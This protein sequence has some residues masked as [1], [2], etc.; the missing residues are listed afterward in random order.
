MTGGAA[1]YLLLALA[2]VGTHRLEPGAAW[3]K[4]PQVT[5]LKPLCGDEVGLEDALLSF[6]TQATDFPVHYVFGATDSADP[7]L[8][9]CR[10]VAARFPQHRADFVI[11]ASVQGRNP[12]ISNLINMSRTTLGDIVV[13]SDSD[14]VI[15]PGTLQAAIDA[16]A[17]PGVG[18]ATTLYRARPAVA[19]DAVRSFGAW[20]VDYWDLPMQMLSARLGP[21]AVAYGPLTAVHRSVLEE[22]GGLGSLADQLCDD[23]ALGRQ[24]R[25]AGYD[26]VFTPAIAETLVNDTRLGQLFQHELRWARTARGLQPLGYAASVVAMPGPLPLLLLLHPGVLTALAAALPVALRWAIARRVARRFGRAETLAVPGPVG[27]WLR[28]CA[29]W[30]VWA[31]AFGVNRVRWRG[32]WLPLRDDVIQGSPAVSEPS[33]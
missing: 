4:P 11:D 2:A 29:C 25:A 5:L 27:L 20:Y 15:A 18:A 16:L 9:L 28:D 7:A 22:I 19:G 31:A 14:I 26:V 8:A 30:L 21:L 12:K 13:I 24:I 32:Q 17:K 6:F 1:A 23:A 10:A 33:G 3:P